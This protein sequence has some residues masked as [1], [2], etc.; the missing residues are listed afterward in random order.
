MDFFN[1][2]KVREKYLEGTDPHEFQI[3]ELSERNF[4]ITMNNV[5]IITAEN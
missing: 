3:M 1:D 4:K 5:Y 2:Q